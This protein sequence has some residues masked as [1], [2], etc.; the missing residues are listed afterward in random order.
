[1]GIPRTKELVHRRRKGVT[2]KPAPLRVALRPHAPAQQTGATVVRSVQKY[3]VANVTTRGRARAQR[4]IF[5]FLELPAELRV[6]IY[7]LLLSFKGVTRFLADYANTYMHELEGN[8]HPYLRL[9]TPGILLVSRFITSEALHEISKVPLTITHF[10][11]VP[12]IT[13]VICPN[14]LQSV[15]HVTIKI[16][17]MEEIYW[18]LLQ[19]RSM[20]RLA[21]QLSGL[22][23]WR[24]N[25]RKLTIA[26]VDP[27]TERHLE[28]CDPN[29][30][31]VR[32]EIINVLDMFDKLRGIKSV[33]FEGVLGCF[34]REA[35]HKMQR[36]LN[37]SF[38]SLPAE[39]RN[40]IY[41]YA[42]DWS[43]ASKLQE[44]E[45][46]EKRTAEEWAALEASTDFA[47]RRS[48]PTGLL[49][50][51]QIYAEAIVMLHRKFLVLKASPLKI[52]ITNFITEATLRTVRNLEILIDETYKSCWGDSMELRS[53]L[54]KIFGSG[55]QLRAVII[56]I[57]CPGESNRVKNLYAKFIHGLDEDWGCHANIIGL[58]LLSFPRRGQMC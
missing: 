51:R 42:V 49:I 19:V 33:E 22:W 2:G 26:L 38:L 11:G 9:S 45:S 5:R 23:L 36:P 35:A 6:M 47:S 15:T 44:K 39:L 14:I 37:F 18:A 27:R 52:N 30:C 16:R 55:N 24:H 20:Q 3:L 32:D 41:S 53:S 8:R 12:K 29:H 40:E 17:H 1:M 13:Q 7:V 25:L 21:E 54:S 57:K 43:D 10:H 50:N 56:R 34:G 46:L 28:M 4:A 58:S 31:F 48:T